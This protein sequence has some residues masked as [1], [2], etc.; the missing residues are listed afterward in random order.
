MTEH[1]GSEGGGQTVS[2]G[3]ETGTAQQMNPELSPQPG[4]KWKLVIVGLIA[5]FV[6]LGSYDVITDSSQIALHGTSSSSSA[7][8]TAGPT[9]SGSSSAARTATASQ[10]ASAAVGTTTGP[11]SHPLDVVSIVAFGPGGTADGDNPGLAS[12][13][14]DVSSNQPWYSQWYATP[15]FGGMRAGTGLLLDMGKRTTI[16]RVQLVLGSQPGATV[17]VRVGDVASLAGLSTVATATDAH[18]SVRLTAT[19]RAS[20]RY[21]LIWFTRLPP[22]GQGHYQIDVYGA[23][24]DGTAGA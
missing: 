22:D 10:A 8:R 12:H 18:G 14:L 11:A 15:D 6:L 24:V 19:A 21:V 23:E 20:G 3:T 4:S 7:S 13:I 1:T 16:S 9:A 2:S 5:A 17:Q